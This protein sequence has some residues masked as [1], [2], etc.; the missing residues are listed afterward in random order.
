MP[1]PGN[2]GDLQFPVGPGVRFDHMLYQGYTVP[3]FYDSLLDKL[4]VSSDTRPR[5]I[6][7]LERAVGEIRVGGF[8]TTAPIFLALADAGPNGPGSHRLA[9]R[10]AGRK[11]RGVH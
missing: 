11:R 5:A 1:F 4:I 8:R 9:R 7:R 3:P 10:L 6:D 2:V